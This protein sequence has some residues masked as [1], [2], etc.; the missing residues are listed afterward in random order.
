MP[1]SFESIFLSRVAIFGW[2]SPIIL[3]IYSLSHSNSPK[4]LFEILF[5]ALFILEK[6]YDDTVLRGDVWMVLWMLLYG[7]F[8]T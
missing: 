7:D 8:G 5:E 6:Y 1:L 2:V 4:Y 3:D